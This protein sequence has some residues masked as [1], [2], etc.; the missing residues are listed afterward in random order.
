MLHD[1]GPGA[2]R[3]LLSRDKDTESDAR[4]TTSTKQ[5]ESNDSLS[6]KCPSS[7]LG[8]NLRVRFFRIMVILLL[9]SENTYLY[10]CRLNL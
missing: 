2:C 1:A 7:T 6:R 10:I 5:I 4:N 9:E 8:E 3:R